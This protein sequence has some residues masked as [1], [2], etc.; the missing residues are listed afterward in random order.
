MAFKLTALGSTIAL[1]ANSNTPEDAVL[2][3][4]YEH[5]SDWPIEVDELAG[6]LHT[7]ESAILKITNNMLNSDRPF[8]EEA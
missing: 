4:L 3:Y 7:T 6:E 8:I 5:R 2:T 1:K